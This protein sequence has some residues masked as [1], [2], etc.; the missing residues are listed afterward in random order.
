MHSA[1]PKI[2]PAAQHHLP[3][4]L[5]IAM[6]YTLPIV[7]PIPCPWDAKL[8]PVLIRHPGNFLRSSSRWL[9]GQQLFNNIYLTTIVCQP[10]VAA[11]MLTALQSSTSRPT[12]PLNLRSRYLLWVVSSLALTIHCMLAAMNVLAIGKIC[13]ATDF[14]S[15]CICG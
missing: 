1:Q 3:T 14:S 15:S 12:T 4:A 10:C 5:P 6:P 13:P 2:T 8:A 9:R 11:H 7:L